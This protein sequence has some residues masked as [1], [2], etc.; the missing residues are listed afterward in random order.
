[1]EMSGRQASPRAG[2]LPGV[3]AGRASTWCV[4]ASGLGPPWPAG[5]GLRSVAA[6][7]GQQGPAQVTGLTGL[8]FPVCR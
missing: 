5:Q 6:Y 4:A 8:P 1:M 3:A 2:I 7:R